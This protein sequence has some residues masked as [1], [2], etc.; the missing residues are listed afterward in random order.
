MLIF[1]LYFLNKVN[2]MVCAYII[3]IVHKTIVALVSVP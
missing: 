3:G 2:I 1:I